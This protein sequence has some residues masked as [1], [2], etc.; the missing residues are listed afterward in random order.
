MLL[1]TPHMKLLLAIQPVDF[2]KGIP[3]LMGLCKNHLKE[4]PFSGTLFAFRNRKETSVKVLIYDGQGFWLCTKRFSDGKLKW[5][6]K[7]Q[8][9]ASQITSNE[10]QI[11]LAKG[12]PVNAKLGQEWVPIKESVGLNLY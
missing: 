9:V 11:L 10:L 12:T 6:P 3:G 1:L 8:G 2:R 5:W 7:S 4:D